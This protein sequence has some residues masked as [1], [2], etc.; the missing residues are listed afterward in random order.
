MQEE[1][2]G[3]EYTSHAPIYYI[4]RLTIVG[5]VPGVVGY[6]FIKWRQNRLWFFSLSLH[7]T[8]VFTYLI[9]LYLFFRRRRPVLCGRRPDENNPRGR[10]ESV[11]GHA[12]TIGRIRRTRGT[13]GINRALGGRLNGA[14]EEKNQKEKGL[15][16]CAS[17]HSRES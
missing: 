6:L 8:A 2:K 14:V 13:C 11:K 7:L 17:F 9:I 10:P 4:C 1:R 15:C 5:K 3:C 16:G 12:A